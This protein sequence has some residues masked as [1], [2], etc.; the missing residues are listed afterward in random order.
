MQFS[1]RIL[2][3]FL[4]TNLS[5]AEIAI[6]LDSIGFEVEEMT[7]YS[8]TLQNIVVAKILEVTKHP[9]ADTLSICKVTDGSNIFQVVCGCE[10]VKP[11]MLVALA[12]VG[13]HIPEGN[14]SIKK[15]KLRGEISEGM[16]CSGYELGIEANSEGILNLETTSLLNC[17]ESNIHFNQF[18]SLL[19]TMPAYAKLQL[20]MEVSQV[21]GLSTIIKIAVTPNRGDMMSVYGIA[22]ELAAFD[23]GILRSM[24]DILNEIDHERILINLVK[25]AEIIKK[26][27][28]YF[29]L[30]Y[31]IKTD[32]S[33]STAPKWLANEMKELGL[34]SISTAVDIT[35]YVSQIF[36]HPSHIYHNSNLN[37]E[38]LKFK[39]IE[40]SSSFQ[41]L[42]GESY[43]LASEDVVIYNRNN[44]AIEGLAGIMGGQNNMCQLDTTKGILEMGIFDRKAVTATGQRLNIISKARQ[45]F[46]RGVELERLELSLV[47]CLKLFEI[48]CKTNQVYSVTKILGCKDTEKP[49]IFS[50][51]NDKVK[52]YLSI[53][54][55]NIV[56]IFKKMNYKIL[57]VNLDSVE[58]SPPRYRT[59]LSTIQSIFGEVARFIGYDNIPMQPLSLKISSSADEVDHHQI[60][61]SNKYS[62]VITWSFVCSTEHD[63]FFDLD[64]NLLIKNPISSNLDSLRTSPVVNFLGLFNKIKRM[65]NRFAIFE[66]GPS[67]Y[68]NKN[69]ILQN[70]T[71]FGM[72]E[73]SKRIYDNCSM[74]DL[75]ED[76][77][78]LNSY[79][80][81]QITLSPKYFDQNSC[82]KIMHKN[83]HVGYVG[84]VNKVLMKNCNINPEINLGYFEIKLDK[85]K[86][87]NVVKLSNHPIA[88][89]DFSFILPKEFGSLAMNELQQKIMNFELIDSS[90]PDK[91]IKTKIVKDLKIF[92]FYH[93][94]KETKR[95][96]IRIWLQHDI[97]TLT[98]MQIN[99][100][101]DFVIHIT[102]HDYNLT[103]NRDRV[104]K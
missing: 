98:D 19:P 26:N 2:K 43:E 25:N 1:I 37:L 60:M 51:N 99:T 35:N 39:E 56:E 33:N 44:Q 102:N 20:G 15:S 65:S 100:F 87:E 64:P 36:G 90:N 46:E 58:V 12:K 34:K 42:D 76:I 53:E 85:I 32:L 41:A 52:N 103:L 61:S 7:Q 82:A 16:L 14:F 22:R 80:F 63:Q 69:Q 92:D 27:S 6:K 47:F 28:E 73:I 54:V 45:K 71:I 30:C 93:D 83:T 96:G 67:Y 3:R 91:Q 97:N 68:V 21:L 59:D 95:L 78:G 86:Q 101:Q 40:C 74:A 4:K 84:L 55:E 77:K 79:T 24:E 9:K 57:Q 94:N 75:I 8:K 70:E 89:R 104:N 23:F 48:F 13:A 11:E 50:I 62:E 31:F 38:V 5:D 17:N 81:D 72:K 88:I 66:I 49:L 10:T 18:E 29:D